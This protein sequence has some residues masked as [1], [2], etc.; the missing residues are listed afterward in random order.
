MSDTNLKME[1]H[2]NRSNP[3]LLPFK[4]SRDFPLTREWT[5]RYYNE[6]F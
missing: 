3:K 5:D 1:K 6:F 4:Y 2:S